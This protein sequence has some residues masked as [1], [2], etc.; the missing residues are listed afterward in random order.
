M[1]RRRAPFQ[2]ALEPAHAA[3]LFRPS[4]GGRD[5]HHPPRGQPSPGRVP[6]PNRLHTR[7][8]QRQPLRNLLLA[9]VALGARLQLSA[10][11]RE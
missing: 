4:V 11:V 10:S 8:A 1:D 7:A 5:V 9:P 3:P 2:R 6:V